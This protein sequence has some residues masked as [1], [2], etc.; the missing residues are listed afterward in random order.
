MFMKI[1]FKHDVRKGTTVSLVVNDM[2]KDSGVAFCVP[3]E[4]FETTASIL[5]KLA[6]EFD[7]ALLCYKPVVLE[8]DIGKEKGD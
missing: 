2:E 3:P 6:D 4:D 5:R 1:H 8:F 7:K